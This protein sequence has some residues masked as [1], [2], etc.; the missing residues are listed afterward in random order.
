MNG[1]YYECAKACGR[2][3]GLW[4]MLAIIFFAAFTASAICALILKFKN[5]KYRDAL[6]DVSERFPNTAE[7][8]EELAEIRRREWGRANAPSNQMTNEERLSKNRVETEE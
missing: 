7:Q 3:G 2:R 1:E 5:N 8:E 4:K 6:I